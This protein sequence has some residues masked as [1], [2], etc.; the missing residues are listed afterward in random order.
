[1]L[2]APISRYGVR[3]QSGSHY[4]P[5]RG[6]SEASVY[7]P[8]TLVRSFSF[9]LAQISNI[10]L[11]SDVS[12]N[13]EISLQCYLRAEEPNRGG[14]GLADDLG[15]DIFLGGIKFVPDFDEMG[16]QDQWY[17]VVGGTGKVQIG[18]S[19]Q[20][21]YGQSLNVDDFELI[22]VIGKGSFGKVCCFSSPPSP[23]THSMKGDA[24]QEA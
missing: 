21:S 10:R 8:G 5:W 1:M 14:D 13:S 20:P 15:N 2:V 23:S 24:S 4:P 11:Y 19:Y 18:V 3:S 6:P 16:S 9:I 7:V 22:T 17:E 12:R